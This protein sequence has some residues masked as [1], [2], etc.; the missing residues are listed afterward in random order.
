MRSRFLIDPDGH[1]VAEHA[2]LKDW[3]PRASLQDDEL[4]RY[5]VHNVGY[6]HM[7]REPR[8]MHV[9]LDVEAI[10]ESAAAALLFELVD[11]QDKT[12]NTVS[13][14]DHD[15]VPLLFPNAHAALKYVTDR[16]RN[17]PSSRSPLFHRRR[18]PIIGSKRSAFRQLISLCS[19]RDPLEGSTIRPFLAR[20]FKSRFLI[21][22]SDTDAGRLTLTEAGTGY[23]G[24]DD[25]WRQ[26]AVGAPFGHFDDPRYSSFVVEAYQEARQAAEPILEEIDAT[27]RIGAKP[28]AVVSYDRLLVPIKT[29]RGQALLSATLV[30]H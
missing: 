30:D 11:Y 18:V 3:R 5:L 2:I 12:R 26:R 19:A 10:S 29:T 13:V 9:S 27:M 8:R 25:G 1:S 28:P 4:L 6:V 17:R 14:S 16:L 23:P 7:R 20:V 21:L 22:Q 24:L 15:N